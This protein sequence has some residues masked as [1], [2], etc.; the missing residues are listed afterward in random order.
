MN[1]Q[2]ILDMYH[3]LRTIARCGG[4][5]EQYEVLDVLSS[6][7]W[8][9]NFGERAYALRMRVICDVADEFVKVPEEHE[10][11]VSRARDYMEVDP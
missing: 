3:E 11:M 10:A 4:Y 9:D 5:R 7:T 6:L 1:T 2:P 8:F